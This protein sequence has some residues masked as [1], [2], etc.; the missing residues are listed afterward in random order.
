MTIEST[1]ELDAAIEAYAILL[2]EDRLLLENE[3][4]TGDRI[5]RSFKTHHEEEQLAKIWA[6]EMTKNFSQDQYN[7]MRSNEQIHGSNQNAKLAE[8]AFKKFCLAHGIAVTIDPY[9]T[10]DEEDEADV[11]DDKKQILDLDVKSTLWFHN[12]LYIKDR[13]YPNGEPRGLF[14]IYPVVVIN[15]TTTYIKGYLD[16]DLLMKEILIQYVH[17]NEPLSVGKG[18]TA[19]Y[20]MYDVEY[21]DKCFLDGDSDLRKLLDMIE[22]GKLVIKEE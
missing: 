12:H 8:L 10:K 17:V 14:K 11:V 4:A 1:P 2:D 21:D 5:I 15:P 22:Q 18:L 9:L 6:R 3:R 16:S 20:D 19:N 13:K 7:Q